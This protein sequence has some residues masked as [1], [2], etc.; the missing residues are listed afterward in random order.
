MEI[1]TRMDQPLPTYAIGRINFININRLRPPRKASLQGVDAEADL[2][3]R[4]ENWKLHIK[5]TIS[6]NFT[7]T[8]SKFKPE[9]D[10]N[11][12]IIHLDKNITE[13]L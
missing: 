6:T 11:V 4:Y 7:R 1:V 10:H 3:E 13:E 9:R 12:T 2:A 8:K 5:K